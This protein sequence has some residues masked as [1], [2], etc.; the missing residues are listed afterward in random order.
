VRPRRPLP[1]H[2]GFSRLGIYEKQAVGAHSICAGSYVF[3][4]N[5]TVA[6]GRLK[7]KI[8]KTPKD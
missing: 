4:S 1:V 2:R 5:Q 7:P 3:C 6:N 8:S